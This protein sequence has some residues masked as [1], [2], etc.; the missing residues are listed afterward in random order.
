MEIITIILLSVLILGVLGFRFSGKQKKSE[1]D[2]LE[3]TSDAQAKIVAVMKNIDE[4]DENDLYGI[5][6]TRWVF[7]G[8]NGINQYQAVR[9]CFERDRKT[10]SCC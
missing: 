6:V 1:E 7:E 2:K 5:S 10:F 9:R 8:T 4:L 3:N